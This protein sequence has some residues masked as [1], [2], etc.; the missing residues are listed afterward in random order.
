MLAGQRLRSEQVAGKEPILQG[1]AHDATRHVSMT[2]QKTVRA[3]RP[4]LLPLL[5]H[6]TLLP[7]LFADD[8]EITLKSLKDG[9][10]DTAKRLV[11]YLTPHLE[12]VREAYGGDQSGITVHQVGEQDLTQKGVSGGLSLF[13][14]SLGGS[15]SNTRQREV[16]D[17]V[18]QATGSKWGYD[19]STERFRPHSVK[20]FKLLTGSESLQ[21]DENSTAFLSVGPEN[22]Y[23]EETPIPSSFTLKTAGLSSAAPAAS[24]LGPYNGVPIGTVL[25][26]VGDRLPNG[27]AWFDE[28]STYPDASWVPKALRLQPMASTKGY[29][30]GGAES[31]GQVG[32]PFTAGRVPVPEH[33]V[34]ASSFQLK[35]TP[36]KRRIQGE[37]RHWGNKYNGAWAFVLHNE[38]S[39]EKGGI[40]PMDQRFDIGSKGK[41]DGFLGFFQ[42][43]PAEYAYPKL[44]VTGSHTVAKADV[45]LD[46]AQTNSRHV[47]V[48][49]VIRIR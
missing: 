17:R 28:G 8:G 1:E 20:K 37:N 35:D 18:E 42:P 48:R 32:T 16:L 9:D 13:G 19:K 47:R 44:S 6:Q 24:D 40:S 15:L 45:P 25:P 36:D 41:K 31:D 29:L 3:S 49:F 14:L 39:F 7:K 21:I 2:V 30:L 10:A 43:V 34:P 26:F 12:Q 38:E 46:T 33:T 23:L 5:D 27:Y 22:R 11:E 4:D